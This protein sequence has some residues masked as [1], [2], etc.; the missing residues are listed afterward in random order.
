MKRCI[1]FIG[2][3]VLFL[4]PPDVWA[5]LL[6]GYDI[7][8]VAGQSNNLAGIGRDS[9]IDVGAPN[10]YQLG[11]YSPH[12]N[13]II[14]ATEPLEFF[15][16]RQ[17]YIGYGLKFARL[18]QTVGYGTAKRPLLILPAAKGGTGFSDHNW[19]PGDPL[20]ADLVAKANLLMNLPNLTNRIIAF[21]WL[22]GENDISRGMS[23][24]E[25]ETRWLAM[26]NGFQHDVKGFSAK[27]PIL[28]GQMVPSWFKNLPNNKGIN[29]NSAHQ[30]LPS[31]RAHTIFVSAETPYELG[32]NDEAYL[33][34]ADIPVHYSAKS[35][36]LLAK[37]FFVAFRRLTVNPAD[38]TDEGNTPEDEV[39]IFDYN[40]LIAGFGTTYDISDYNELLGR[41]GE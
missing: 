36:R 8:I 31:R 4:F 28:I 41:F 7:I 1:V 19:N 15:T 11:R 17:N 16:F 37:R 20:Y 39:N 13:Q 27:T 18:L 10:I 2:M 9:A 5:E 29:I 38:L 26:V 22:Q 24:D 34:I 3:L 33:G 32:N 12:E 35:Q 14:P 30:H 25:Y 40:V 23:Q 6:Q 21:T